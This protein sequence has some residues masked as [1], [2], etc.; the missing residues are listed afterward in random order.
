MFTAMT[1]APIENC[2]E[3]TSGRVNNL[4]G[5]SETAVR[6][7]FH[8]P[9]RTIPCELELALLVRSRKG[10]HIF[11]ISI[12]GNSRATIRSKY[13]GLETIL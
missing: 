11:Y 8:R 7:G 10:D 1:G 2:R 5:G 3:S 13:L 6:A 12:L 9:D 4:G